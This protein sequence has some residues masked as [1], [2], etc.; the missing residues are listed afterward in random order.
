MPI[1]RNDSVTQ[2]GGFPLPDTSTEKLSKH[3][4]AEAA[5][6]LQT[7][8]FKASNSSTI[9]SVEHAFDCLTVEF[10]NGSVYEY[11]GVPESI[12]REL[13]SAKSVGSTFA[14]LVRS[15]YESTRIA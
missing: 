11:R 3:P 14:S 1:Y 8:Q 10:K 15:K 6:E 13:E 7:K 2:V 5:I 4:E 9:E 12:Y